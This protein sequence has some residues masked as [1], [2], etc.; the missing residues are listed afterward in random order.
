MSILDIIDTPLKFGPKRSTLNFGCSNQG[1][2]V[3]TVTSGP[4]IDPREKISWIIE[5]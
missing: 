1:L 5:V 2:R 4:R 3:P